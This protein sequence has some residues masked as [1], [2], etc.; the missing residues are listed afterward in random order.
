MSNS[1]A[2]YFS[3][4]TWF[5]RIGST[6]HQEIIFLTLIPL[7]FFGI[8]FNIIALF[9]LKDNS[10]KLPIY[11]YMRIYTLNSILVCAITMTRFINNSRRFFGFSNTN[12]AQMYVTFFYIATSNIIYTFGGYLDCLLLLDRVILLSGRMQWFKKV[13][14]K[15][16]CF[17]VLILTCIVLASNFFMYRPSKRVVYLNATETFTLYGFTASSFQ[18]KKIGFVLFHI[19]NVVMSPVPLV[20]EIFLCIVTVI[21]LKK[22]TLKK[23]KLSIQSSSSEK[24]IRKTEI[25]MTIVVIVLTLFSIM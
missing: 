2:V 23:R 1:T 18:K 21:F 14:P 17:F 11:Q 9:I 6:L 16:V 13:S 22:F 10:L 7:G 24:K 3:L 19:G 20:I 4:N 5:N 25:K 8:I 12:G 15:I